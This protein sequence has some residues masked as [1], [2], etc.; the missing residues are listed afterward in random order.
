MAL[1][2][3][4]I[5]E[6]DT[7]IDFDVL[8]SQANE[9]YLQ[10]KTENILSALNQTTY[11]MKSNTPLKRTCSSVAFVTGTNSNTMCS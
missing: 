4:F 8:S 11:P 2:H 3:C 7:N 9:D 6:T 5:S 10:G 1:L